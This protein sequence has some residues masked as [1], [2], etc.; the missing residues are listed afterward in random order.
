MK[1]SFFIAILNSA[2]LFSIAKKSANKVI[3]SKNHGDIFKSDANPPAIALRRN[4]AEIQKIS[5]I[6]FFFS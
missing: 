2:F 6:G 5:N 4:P 1:I 3:L